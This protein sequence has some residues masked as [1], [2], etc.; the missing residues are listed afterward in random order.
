LKIFYCGGAGSQAALFA[1]AIH[2]GHLPEKRVPT[3][4]EISR[5]RDLARCERS[6]WGIPC[7]LGAD[8]TGNEVYAIELGTDQDIS[9]Q[10]IY[11]LLNA[12]VD[13]T[14]WKFYKT[15]NQINPVL[16]LGGFCER[17][18][19]LASAGRFLVVRGI[20]TGYF[21]LVNQVR[22]IKEWNL[23]GKT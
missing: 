3:G 14:Q 5:I 2:L 19:H 7:L 4:A 17:R 13:P 21:D 10:A 15:P 11:H 9:L 1:G 23:I 22:Q 12:A 18:L 6:N 8:Q 20:Q 16:R